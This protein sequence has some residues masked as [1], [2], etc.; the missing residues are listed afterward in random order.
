MW[1]RKLYKRAWDSWSKIKGIFFKVIFEDKRF[2]RE[3]EEGR[4]YL[5]M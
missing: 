4:S 1:L 2:S 5:S 3:T